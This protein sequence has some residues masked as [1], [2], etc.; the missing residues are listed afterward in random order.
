MF[1]FPKMT[2]GELFAPQRTHSYNP[3]LRPPTAATAPP[4]AAVDAEQQD[5]DWYFTQLVTECQAGHVRATRLSWLLAEAGRTEDELN[6][7]LA[8]NCV[9]GTSATSPVPTLNRV[10]KEAK[11]STTS[12][13][14]AKSQ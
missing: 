9:E 3:N 6:A 10:A 12:F 2:F 11:M 7:A 5:R 4:S 13:E 8:A 14:N 1:P